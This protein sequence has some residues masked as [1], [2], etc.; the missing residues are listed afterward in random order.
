MTKLKFFDIYEPI[1]TSS[2]AITISKEEMRKVMAAVRKG[3]RLLAKKLKDRVK[4]VPVEI[5]KKA[6]RLSRLRDRRWIAEYQDFPEWIVPS[7]WGQPPEQ[8][9][10]AIKLFKKYK[11]EIPHELHDALW[12]A[13]RRKKGELRK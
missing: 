1:D 3:R 7:C 11:A 8:I 5:R 9:E 13:N 10:R 2:P 4:A 6:D 12:L